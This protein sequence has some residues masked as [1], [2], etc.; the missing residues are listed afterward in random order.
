MT[1]GFWRGKRVF[2]TGHTGF[3]GAWAA[4]WLSRLGARVHGYSRAPATE[5]NLYD[6]ANITSLLAGETIADICSREDVERAIATAKPEVVIHMAAQTLVRASYQD[7]AETFATN[8]M[9]TFHLLDALRRTDSARAIVIVTSDKCYEN[10][11][12]GKAFVETDRLGGRDPYSASKACQEILTGA[13]RNSYF[14]EQALVA[15]ARGGNVLGGGD[16]AEDRLVPDIVRAST[17]GRAMIVRY[18]DAIRPWQYIFDPLAGYFLLAEALYRGDVKFAG[19]WNFAPPPENAIS[20]RAV[21]EK[22]LHAYGA[23]VKIEMNAGSRAHEARFLRLDASKSRRDLGWRPQ[24]DLDATLRETAGWYRK[25]RKGVS[26]IKACEES[27]QGY[28]AE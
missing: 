26:A 19:G 21:I 16:W 22:F 13:M 9:G 23:N 27:L 17:N 11:E 8:I 1:P 28:A 2:L 20:V 18:P 14:Q 12:T 5:P 4:L 15:T 6:L 7:P 10:D 25:V 24:Y 3:K